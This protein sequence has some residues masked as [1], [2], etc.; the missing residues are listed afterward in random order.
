M[1]LFGLFKKKEKIK[2]QP[3]VNNGISK[4][5]IIKKMLEQQS[6]RSP[7]DQ[8]A[9][10]AIFDISNKKRDAFEQIVRSNDALSLRKFFADCYS[11]FLTNPEIVGFIPSMVNKN[12]NDTSPETWNT[13][14]FNFSDGD[15]VA[16][17]FMPIQN[18]SLAARIVGIVVS[19]KGDGY[20]Y[21]MVNKDGNLFS[22]VMRNKAIHGVEKSEKL[23]GLALT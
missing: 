14:I 9:S 15:C 3:D 11:S 22:N 13:D 8:F 6:Q 7:S 21:C 17:L 20:Y 19:Q 10:G 12:N 2:T 23:K 1:G 18:D 16:L 5:D 4:E